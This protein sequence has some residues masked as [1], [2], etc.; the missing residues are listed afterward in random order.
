ML[1]FKLKSKVVGKA[2]VNVFLTPNCLTDSAPDMEPNHKLLR[3]WFKNLKYEV[4]KDL[5][6][7]VE[8]LLDDKTLKLGLHHCCWTEGRCFLVV[9]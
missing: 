8:N 9:R 4:I 7:Y 6:K 1:I 3:N 2:R 5:T